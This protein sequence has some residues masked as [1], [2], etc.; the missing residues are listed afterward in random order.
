MGTNCVEQRAASD[1]YKLTEE[2]NGCEG[3]SGSSIHQVFLACN[4]LI[5]L[6]VSANSFIP[7]IQLKL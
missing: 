5:F 2:G 7:V 1:S 3:I 6:Y 4:V